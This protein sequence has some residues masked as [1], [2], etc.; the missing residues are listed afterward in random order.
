MVAA[1]HRRTAVTMAMDSADLSERQACRYLG[2]ARSSQ[3]CRI[4]RPARAELRERLHTLAI[5]RPRWAIAGCVGCGGGRVWWS[6]T[7]SCSACTAKRDCT[8]YFRQAD[9]AFRAKP[10]SRFAPS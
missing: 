10:I 9:R 7:S 8:A 1:E 5:L 6:I 3:R 2:F 4:R